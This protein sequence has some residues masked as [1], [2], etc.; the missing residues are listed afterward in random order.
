MVWIRNSGTGS[1]FVGNWTF[2]D[3]DNGNTYTLDI[4]DDGSVIVIGYIVYCNDDGESVGGTFTLPNKTISID[5]N[6]G[7]WDSGDRVY[8]DQGGADC[9]DVPGLDLR[10]VYLA[11]DNTYIYIR[12]VLNGP[13]NETFAYKFG[14]AFRHLFVAKNNSG[15]YINYASAYYNAVDLPSSFVRVNDNQFEAKFYKSDVE[16][17]WIGEQLDAWLDQGVA[18]ICRDVAELPELLINW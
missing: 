8:Q 3:T 10:E 16:E 5:G 14:E 18:T 13:L 6:F 12:Y 7:D 9:D 15:A 17:Y 2:Y 4:V 1:D 11:Q